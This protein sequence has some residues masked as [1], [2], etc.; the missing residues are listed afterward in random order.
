MADLRISEL[1][2]LAGANLAADDFLPIADS[3]ASETKKITVTDL[4]GNATTLIADGT[5]PGAKIVFGSGTI[6]AS[7]LAGSSITAS[8]LANDAVTAA[9]LADESS[10]DLV[11]TLPGSGAF[12]GQIALDTD[13]SK[14]Y[15][16]NGST[17][18]SVKGAGSVNAVLGSTAGVINIVA[19][20]VG[21]EVTIS[22]T[23]DNT[24]NAAEFLAGPTASAGTVGYRPIVGADLPTATTTTKGAVVVNGNGLSLSGDTIIVNN[25]VT[26]EASNFHI[27]QYTSKGL[28][29][30][31]R[32]IDAGDLPIAT[33][34]SNGILQPG[35]GLNVT[36]TGTLNHNNSVGTGSGVKVSFDNE[37]HVTGV[38]ALSESDIPN[39]SAAKITTGTLD[40][41]RIGTNTVIGSK[42]A[43]FSVSKIGADTPTPDHIGQFFFN[44]ISRDLFLWD[45]NVYQPVGISA[46]EIVFAGTYDAATNLLTSVT[47]QGLAAGFTNN[48]V[49]PAAS[50]LN[51]RYYVV[52]SNTGTGASPAP[53]TALQPPDLLLSN[54][55][56]YVLVDVSQTVT[57]QTA[58]TV[59]FTPTGGISSNNVQGAIAEVDTEKLAKA[60]DTLT[61]QLL[62][63]N[64]GSLV[65][66]G[67]TDNAFETTLGVVDPTA[68]RTINLPDISGTVITTG[69]T[70]SV[71]ST[72]ILDGTILNADVNASAA[73][74]GTKISPDFGSQAITTTGAFTHALGTSSVPTITF[75]GDPNTGIYSPGA[76]QV[77]ISTNGTGRLFVDAS[78]NVGLNASTPN[79]YGAGYNVFTVNGSTSPVIDLNVGGTRTAT[80]YAFSTNTLI[81]TQTSTPLQIITNGTE[82]ARITSDGKLGL[83]TSSPSQL[84]H[85]RTTTGTAG[86]AAAR[87]SVDG[88]SS[89]QTGLE[90][91][92]TP[93]TSANAFRSGRIYSAFD[94]S[95]F[96]DSRITLQSVLNGDI[97][98][99]T[100]TV[101]NGAVGIGTT[102]PGALVD[103]LP[104]AATVVYRARSSTTSA[105]VTALQVTPSDISAEWLGVS[106]GP[107][108]TTVGAAGSFVIN[109][110]GSERARIDTS[111]RLLVGTSTA[112]STYL[113]AAISAGINLE[114]AGSL[115]AN[116]RGLSIVNGYSLSVD[117]DPLL[118]LG[119]T[120]SDSLGGTTIVQNNDYLGRLLFVGS[121]GTNMLAG[122]WIR[123]EVDG[124]PGVN[125]MP[126]RLVFSTTADGA[127]SPTERMRITQN[128]YTKHSN[129]GVYLSNTAAYHEFNNNDTEP[130]I[131]VRSTNASFANNVLQTSA[132][133]AA[134]SA[135]RLFAGYSDGFTDLEFGLYGDGNGKC[136]GSWSGGGADYAEYF[137]W[138]D[139]NPD[140]EDRRGISVV[141]DGD[142]I[143][144]AVDGED[145][146]GVISGNPSVVGDA[147][148]NKWSGKYLRDDFGTYI[149]EDYEVEDEDGSTVIQQRRK[150]NP[151]YDP[152]VEYISREERPEWDCVGLMGKL[153]LRKGQPTGSRWIKMRD[154]SDSVEEWLVR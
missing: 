106:A 82:K 83:G 32:V 134:N 10:V 27:V 130:C 2:T 9:K 81:G 12:V 77:A 33:S 96:A 69:D 110:S 78:G 87:I 116:N 89:L 24:A 41:G 93:S 56:S 91:Y 54:G 68:D 23:L 20:T 21:D 60:G 137:E 70:G 40:I 144:P 49:L 138:S 149:Q 153:R 124:T 67:A 1:A 4:V 39:L 53:V 22:A 46:G 86:S 136:D 117:G 11:T 18:V 128:G 64:T 6:P 150:L 17:W 73:I 8:Q 105:A 133:R 132:T 47:A 100:L 5:I 139:S 36:N 79:S 38:A 28:I 148:W 115:G 48:A 26:A 13:D 76:D 120:R 7:A 51:N 131:V 55:T 66:E 42:L 72:M 143:R 85:I 44:P 129:N 80:F 135:Y 104:P 25:S 98:S 114:A 112:R 88:A 147:A 59:V 61:G 121:D 126:G 154:I 71:T 43:N 108:T 90:F 63:G 145:P 75:T 16:W 111:G 3:S 31:G 62:V 122:A 50:A 45:G 84:L 35:T 119:R 29:T 125:D 127:S 19:T 99:D 113:A 95:A 140:A 107:T 94:G 58:S 74:A 152:D 142:K 37:G 30:A 103:S 15:C 34:S 57:A 123:G 118:Y 97:L 92:T 14:I 151:A 109:T 102:S 146:I 52:V 101:K 141:L 65:F